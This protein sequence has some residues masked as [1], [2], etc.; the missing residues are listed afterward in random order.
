MRFK[1]HI[2]NTYGCALFQHTPSSNAPKNS[3]KSH[4]IRF[5]LIDNCNACRLFI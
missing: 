4:N 2:Q 1:N 3:G 5:K